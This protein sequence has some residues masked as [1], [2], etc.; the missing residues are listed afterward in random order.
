MKNLIILLAFLYSFKGLAQD[1]QLFA[2]T[3][4]LQKVVIEQQEYY[5]PTPGISATLYFTTTEFFVSHPYCEDGFGTTIQYVAGNGFMNSNGG[6][7]L[8]GV[9]GE[10]EIIEF[11]RRHYSIYLEDDNDTAKNPFSYALTTVGDD[12][13]LIVANVD[14]DQA[15]YG[16]TQ[17][18][19]KTFE[20][21][22]FAIF[23]N[24]VQHVLNFSDLKQSETA[25]LKVY[26][27][28]G[29]EVLSESAVNWS[30][31]SIDVGTLSNGIYMIRV[32][33]KDGAL[34]N[35]KFVKY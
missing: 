27:V 2:N 14:G 20:Q 28:F 13:T 18:T 15:I 10:P 3:W 23:P 8:I 31:S 11:Y 6:V 33:L 29:K 32:Q 24:P 12:S 7:V 35:Q 34:L 1:P 22:E 16:N 30:N 5:F 25:S 21:L 17:L 26:D 19:K 4:Y 9:C